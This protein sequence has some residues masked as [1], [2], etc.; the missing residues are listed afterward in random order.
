M[1]M[2]K[3]MKHLYKFVILLIIFLG[4]LFFF[5]KGIPSISIATTTATSIQDS[6]FPTMYLQLGD[7]TVNTLHGYSSELSSSDVRESIT[8]LDTTKTFIAKIDENDCVIKKLSYDLRD[9]SNSKSI[10][11]GDITAFDKEGSLKT[12][13]IR[14]KEGMD[15]STEYGMKITLITNYSKK[16]HFYTRIKYYEQDFY[17]KQKLEFVSKF[18]DATFDKGQS[19]DLSQYLEANAGSDD[20]FADVDIHS[21]QK[22]VT[23]GKLK[24]KIIS[25]VVPTIKEL[26]VETAAIQQTYFVTANPGTGT[27]TYQIK[28]FYR[29]RYTS[30][31]IYLLY[32]RRTMEAMFD[33]SLI[34]VNKSELKVGISSK[35]DFDL[36]SSE[37]NKNVAF[38]RNGA[39]WLYNMN[40]N[41]INEVFTFQPYNNKRLLDNFDQHDI[42]ILNVD[43]DGN[44]SFVVYGYMNCGDYE[45]RVGILLYDYLAESNQITE[46]VYIPLTTTYEQLKEDFGDFCYVN[47]KNIFYFSINDIVYAYNI[48][49]KR[50]D[51]LTENATADN[52]LMLEAAH[53]FV[54]SDA[55][56]NG[57]ASKL[58]ILDLNS[59]KELTIKAPKNQSLVT[60]G[61][62]DSNVVY[63]FVKN[64]DIYE[65]TTGDTV[66]PAYK[67]I[68]SDCSGN[69]L[70]EYQNKNTYVTSAGVDGN[71]IRLKRVKK[72]RG[73]W[74]KTSDDSIMN[75]KNTAAQ[76]VSL[77]TRVTDKALTE[78]YIS[79]PAGYIMNSLPE[80]QETLS[81]MITEDTTLHLDE[82]QTMKST[83]YYVYAY[84]GITSSLTDPAKAIQL[85][86]E[87]MGVVMDSHSHIVW[88]RGG[89]FIS[90]EL[91]SISYPS[92]NISSTKSCV[93]MLLQAA[94][95]TTSVSDL[96]EKSIM[97]M[98]RAHLDTPVNLTGCTV[99]QILYFV[100][101]EKPVIG[102]LDN[103]HAVLI[104]AYTS[105]TVT[106]MDPATHSKRTV[107]LTTAE[108][109]FKNAGSL[110]FSYI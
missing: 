109:M 75:Q 86:D 29:V 50:H 7:Y 57:N 53:C 93:Q 27:E 8:P 43:N 67:L 14:L 62:I 85:A 33:P 1:E 45:G 82:S 65:S 6:T 12:A 61:T 69:V 87:Q 90:K 40:T 59:S 26:N 37:D 68:I 48:S 46:R 81:V 38:V 22:M 80:V 42:R 100:S 77:S 20:S 64:A 25:D 35:T 104:T 32:F 97:K 103:S 58:T 99:D 105:S 63:G 91:S 66:R 76:A 94:Q 55:S 83:K 71:V 74:K 73:T 17:L 106:W 96:K 16:I 49:S 79:L 9:I 78:K 89:K 108:K 5:G 18:H 101:N 21:S 102:M 31:R 70:R 44:V 84:G 39:L 30:N 54:W 88:E 23:W 11:S 51:I 107:A 19:L 110:F 13:K 72:T 3:Y 15:T 92:N 95:V 24:P 52:F 28:E 56:A 98:L 4:A 36:T 2:R 47:N 34:S 10:E 60:L 41:K